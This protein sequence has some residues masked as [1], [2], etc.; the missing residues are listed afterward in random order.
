MIRFMLDDQVVRVPEGLTFAAL[1]LRI[2]PASLKLKGNLAALDRIAQENAMSRAAL[3]PTQ[4]HATLLLQRWYKAARD[5][6]E[7]VDAY[8]E[9]VRA[10]ALIEA[11]DGLGSM[12]PSPRRPQ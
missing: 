3:C 10:E 1:G 12:M 4:R 8:M 9:D 5:A 11:R 6:G 2:D 7:P